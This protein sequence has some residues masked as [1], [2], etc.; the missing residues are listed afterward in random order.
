MQPSTPLYTYAH[1]TIVDEPF[2][3]VGYYW[4][5]IEGNYPEGRRNTNDLFLW[6]F[7]TNTKHGSVGD[8]PG[9][10]FAFQMPNDRFSPINVTL[11]EGSPPLQS[12][13]PPILTDHGSSM[14]W[15]TARS[16]TYAWV[17]ASDFTTPGT[18]VAE[19]TWGTPVTAS[20]QAPPTL[21]HDAEGF[22]VGPSASAELFRW[23]RNGSDRP[24]VV[25]T[26]PTV[27][28]ARLRI[29][30]DDRYVYY[31]TQAPDN[32]L[33]Q[34][35]SVSLTQVWKIPLAASVEGDMALSQDG[36]SVIVV[37][38]TGAVTCFVVATTA[39]TSLE[40][41]SARNATEE[42]M[43]VELVSHV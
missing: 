7:D 4:S 40:D 24:G 22:V 13:L 11:L 8:T 32:R 30:P 42:M 31:A 14:Y 3:A 9:Q 38:R 26:T 23:S 43:R 37:D 12:Q 15:S 34:L 27:I 17:G 39:T 29:S 20:A 41:V 33:Y 28:R 18:A 36:T 6:S 5:P 21:S 1:P 10:I 25:I 16:R 35:D 19:F 2:G